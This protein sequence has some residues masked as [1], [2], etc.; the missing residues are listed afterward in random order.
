MT[1]KELESAYSSLMYKAAMM[2]MQ[3]HT[4][5]TDINSKASQAILNKYRRQIIA[6]RENELSK[7]N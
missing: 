2:K 7:E 6:E 4:L 5:A 1:K 3:L